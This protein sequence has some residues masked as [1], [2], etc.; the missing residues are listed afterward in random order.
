MF[1]VTFRIGTPEERFRLC[2]GFAYEIRLSRV[3]IGRL[4]SGWVWMRRLHSS[5][6][7]SLLTQLGL[8]D[9][10]I[11]DGSEEVWKGK[12]NFWMSDEM[13]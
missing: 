7:T 4:G 8:R 1:G 6:V 9:T 2:D 12:M 3:E 5:C 11:R 10:T 13:E